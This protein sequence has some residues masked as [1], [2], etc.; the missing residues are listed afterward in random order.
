MSENTQ[1]IEQH[2]EG[3]ARSLVELVGALQNGGL[4]YPLEAY[5]IYL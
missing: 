4:E 5:R 2:A 3:A 1:N